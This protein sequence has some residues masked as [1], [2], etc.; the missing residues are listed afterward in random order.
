MSA[1]HLRGPLTEQ[2]LVDL[3]VQP[4]GVAGI[5][6]AAL[7][8]FGRQPSRHL[9]GLRVQAVRYQGPGPEVGSA[10]QRRTF[11]GP[12]AR[13]V[14]DVV[15]WVVEHVG[16][17]DVISGTR[18]EHVPLLPVPA[19]REVV[20]NALAHREY[21]RT[22]STVDVK[23]WSDRL[24][25]SS[26]GGLPSFITL[27]NIRERHYSRNGRVMQALNELGLVEEF[28]D[29]VDRVFEEME[30]RLLPDPD[31]QADQNS[32]VVTLLSQ[33]D[34]G[35]EEQ[36]WLLLL[37]GVDLSAD[38]R[39]AL[40]RV[41]ADGSVA[42]RDLA[43]L[44]VGRAQHVLAGLVAKGLLLQVGRRGGTRYVLSD[45]VVARAGGGSVAVRQRQ[46]Q[47]L[48]DEAQRR[49]SLATREAAE[50]LGASMDVAR[51]LLRD[52]VSAGDLVPVGQKS[53][54]RYLPQQ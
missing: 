49:G 4:V 42:R 17:H 38:E 46:R 12:M 3:K 52:L 11:D 40:A 41:R 10:S 8:L 45:E 13:V 26:P 37:G 7:A 19:V 33:A 21:G 14:D 23:V 44:R 34:V 36:A 2:M 47:Q 30:R 27:D 35:V 22:G 6:G 28:G 32:V 16:G 24:V 54:R 31:F 20:V 5:C 39:R 25:V 18:R 1:A 9:S 43:T 51:V 29:G 53:G 50:L 15:A 48:R